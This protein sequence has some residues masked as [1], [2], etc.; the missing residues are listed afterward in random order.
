MN[1]QV[2]APARA[3]WPLVSVLIP[4][5]NHER[6]VQRCLDSVLDDPY[7]CKEIVIIDDGSSDATGEKISQWISEHGHRLP[8]H[9]VQRGNRGVA[10]TLNELALSARGEY[11]RLGASDD[12]LLPG[13][14][15]VQVRYL[16]GHPQKRAVI[17]DACVVDARGQ[18][19][20]GSAMRDLHQVDK[21]LYRSDSGI[22][23][24]VIRQWAVSGAVALIRRSAFD[25]RSGWDESLR[26]EDWDFFL[27][28]VAGN[29][30]GFIDLPVCAYRL[31]GS[32]LSKTTNVPARIA[33][34]RESRQVALRCAPL[35]DEPDRTLLRGQS[36]YIAAKVEFLR[37]RPH[38]VA[39]HLVIY[40]GLSLWARWRPK[41]AARPAELA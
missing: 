5:F 34:L 11:L 13:G 16:R 40:A 10:A 35:F 4:A 38:R 33:N 30:L 7:P 6:F 26:I 29:A 21:D 24:A 41:R 1:D 23:H 12:Y 37:R 19:L 9:F 17:G 25:A 28:L 20:H 15:D 31:H 22:R 39:V 8:V 2:P 14:L 18:L 32:N 3:R 36:H 27:R